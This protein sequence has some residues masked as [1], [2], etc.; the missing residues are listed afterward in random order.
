[1][2]LELQTFGLHSFLVICVSRRSP[3]VRAH[4]YS[5]ESRGPANDWKI[6]STKSKKLT[7]WCMTACS[8][9]DDFDYGQHT[10]D[11][12]G[13][14]WKCKLC[15]HGMQPGIQICVKW[16]N[17]ILR[18]SLFPELE[19]FYLLWFHH[20]APL[21]RTVC[22]SQFISL[23][24]TLIFLQFVRVGPFIAEIILRLI[25]Y[26]LYPS[27]IF[28]FCSGSPSISCSRTLVAVT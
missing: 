5:T 21:F 27:E 22:A 13:L 18:S 12:I 2:L 7:S 28:H 4:S 8:W 3:F 1:M 23:K 24:T 6:L 16:S 26:H 15:H 10:R 20:W 25:W 17:W 11:M 19:V 14:A 9:A